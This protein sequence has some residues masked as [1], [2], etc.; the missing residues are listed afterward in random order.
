MNQAASTSSSPSQT[1]FA[2]LRLLGTL[3]CLLSFKGVNALD[4]PSIDTTLAQATSSSPLALRGAEKPVLP[5]S[6]SS[7]MLDKEQKDKGW[8]FGKWA[9]EKAGGGMFYQNFDVKG[10]SS[11]VR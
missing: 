11:H 3:A 2:S 5:V 9:E 4:T 10:D 8:L 6:A 7:A 1:R